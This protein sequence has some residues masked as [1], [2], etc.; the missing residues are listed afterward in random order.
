[1][2]ISLDA[3]V[4]Q[5]I[6][7]RSEQ[8]DRAGLFQHSRQKSLVLAA[9][10]DGVGGQTGGGLAA[11]QVVVTLKNAFEG[12]SANEQTPEQMLKDAINEAHQ[13]IRQ[14]RVLNEQDPNSTG[15]VL[16]LRAQ[17]E[18]MSATWAHCGDSRL[19]HLRGNRVVFQTRDHT[20][21]QQMM[22]K[23]YMTPEQAAVH[24]RR[25]MLVTSLGGEDPPLIDIGS[26]NDLQ[27]GDNFLLCSD[28]LYAY[29]DETELASTV[30]ANSARQ[31]SEKLIN[32]ARERAAGKGDN[33]TVVIV[34][35]EAPKAPAGRAAPRP[36]PG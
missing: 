33:C 32:L 23:G 27:A 21:V 26:A 24:P 22:Q 35:L 18:T 20:Y 5:N 15:V 30:A 31:A 14:G 25:N 10:A 4:G 7:D 29:F 28:G 19:Y 9:V 36:L 1:M 6:G 11:G 3:C 17:G 16:L 8:Q 12:F 2:P 13:M 34:K